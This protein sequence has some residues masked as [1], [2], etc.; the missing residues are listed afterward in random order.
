MKKIPPRKSSGADP[1]TTGPA[2]RRRY[3]IRRP[4][5]DCKKPDGRV[6]QNRLYY[7]PLRV[8]YFKLL[9]SM[10][11]AGRDE[12]HARLNAMREVNR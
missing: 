7:H 5:A 6:A 2:L 4:D 11:E 8:Y 1:I 9:F 3:N 12:A 10:R